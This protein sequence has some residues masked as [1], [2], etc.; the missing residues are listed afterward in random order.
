MVLRVHS[1]IRI[2]STRK[3]LALKKSTESCFLFIVIADTYL[4]K[5]AYIYSLAVLILL[6]FG[7]V[8][9]GVDLGDAARNVVG[10]APARHHETFGVHAQRVTTAATGDCLSVPGCLSP[11]PVYRILQN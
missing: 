7:T 10:A 1:N 2:F 4:H 5:R 3:H 9:I 11:P 8:S 6:L